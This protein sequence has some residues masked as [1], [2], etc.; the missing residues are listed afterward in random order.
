MTIADRPIGDFLAD[1]ASA[2][3]TP[4]GGAVAAVGAAMGAALCEM[5]CIHT[6]GHEDDRAATN[7]AETNAAQG[8]K[9]AEGTDPDFIALRSV[10]G[11]RRERLL[12]L[13]DADVAAVNAVGE[14]FAADVGPDR[15]HEAA[16][17][18]TEVPIETAATARDVLTDAIAVIE[19]GNRNAVPDGVTGAFLAH[20]AVRASTATV[21][22]NLAS[23]ED[24][25]AAT[26]AERADAIEADA[27]RALAA[28]RS[29]TAA[30]DRD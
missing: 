17:R 29:A 23:L 3:V 21:R 15:R 2:R 30:A 13:A 25:P 22:A 18:A 9:D 6:V 24:E 12:E 19:H 4:S 5:V 1:V 7:A 16:E 8:P 28:V 20:A 27:D 14:A 11:D 10:F 26:F